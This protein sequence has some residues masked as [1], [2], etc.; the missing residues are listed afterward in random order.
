MRFHPLWPWPMVI[1]SILAQPWSHANAQNF[2]MGVVSHW[3]YYNNAGWLAFQNGDLGTA[4]KKYT[5]AIKILRPYEKIDQRLLARTYHDLA[6]VLVARKRYADAEQLAK[7]SL[8][9]QEPDLRTK[10]EAIFQNVLLLAQI[11]R[12]RHHD[13][14]A[15]SLFKRVLALQI[16]ALG[17]EHYQIALTLD[18]LAAIAVNLGEYPEAEDLYRRAVA[19]HE[20]VNPL[21]NLAL[22]EALEHYATFLRRDN[23]ATDAESQEFRARTIRNVHATRRAG[24]EAKGM[25]QG[26]PGV[27]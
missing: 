27:K 14:E 3:Q 20:K 19:I 8:H 21:E 22:A 1:L 9:I 5:A 15:E 13:K 17:P 18:D 24:A 26:A 12:E 11:A 16:Q 23:R 4:E 25:T 6:R 10:P 2:P 7:W